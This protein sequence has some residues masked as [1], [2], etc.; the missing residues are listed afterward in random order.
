MI[1]RLLGIYN[2]S[3]G[4]LG[5]FGF[6]LPPLFRN[7]FLAD[8]FRDVWK[9]INIYWRD[10]IQKI[11][12]YPVFFKLK[13]FGT[14]R[15]LFVSIG[16][17]FA[18]TWFFHAY[19]WYWVAGFFPISTVDVYYWLIFGSVITLNVYFYEAKP[20]KILLGKSGKTTFRNSFF[21]VCRIL[22][23]FLFMCFLWTLWNS[24]SVREYVFFMSFL[25]VIS[26]PH[27]L[28]VVAG[29]I[30]AL[31][32]SAI[33]DQYLTNKPIVLTLKYQLIILI[34]TLS[35]SFGMGW[36]GQE[37]NHNESG[38]QK[39]AKDIVEMRLNKRDLEVLERGYYEKM[40]NTN[41]NDGQAWET[42]IRRKREFGNDS[43]ISSRTNDLLMRRLNP[44]VTAEWRGTKFSTNQWA[45]R[46]KE[47]SLEKPEGYFRF[48]LLGSSNELGAGI[49]DG[50]NFETLTE[51]ELNKISNELG[52]Q[53]VEILNM[54]MGGYHLIQTVK[55]AH[56]DIWK[57]NP[58]AIIYAAHTDE[59][60]RCLGMFSRLIQNGVDLEF[61]V[62]KRIHNVSGAK[63]YMSR[64]E[65]R[66]KLKPF[67]KDIYEWG[68]K[69]LA[70]KCKENGAAPVYLFLP[71]LADVYDEKEKSYLFSVAQLN[72]FII[73]DLTGVYND[74]E[75]ETL[76]VSESDYHPNSLGHSIIS[77]LLLKRLI[78][79]KQIFKTEKSD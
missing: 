52:V 59:L 8:S 2:V 43:R 73:L 13:K 47:Y 24:E 7:V 27:L 14:Q 26:I 63:Q 42:R 39:F 5:L 30:A 62:L 40:L 12:Y 54:S 45:M 79:N 21:R 57:F 75:I 22:G 9:R 37:Q 4:L 50:E 16:I 28:L 19:Q 65:I 51:L 10:F 23:V 11:V 25:S 41:R 35:I 58:D 76:R 15:A 61:P 56:S 71:A 33:I 70:L 77:K 1:F 64:S 38:L 20:K 44:N 72:N 69:E 29:L 74:Y 78:E 55:F 48:I 49:N 32:V 18:A 34:F 31:I 36:L 17:A 6:Y 53:G 66:N 68:I 60:Y 3:I 67:E 46:D